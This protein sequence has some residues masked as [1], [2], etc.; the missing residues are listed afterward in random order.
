MELG[1]GWGVED[2]GVE[3]CGVEL[4]FMLTGLVNI[5]G[6]GVAF[7]LVH[8]TSEGCVEGAKETN[9]KECII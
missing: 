1:G 8:H 2:C 5:V 3:D 7:P 6:K 4:T 9:S